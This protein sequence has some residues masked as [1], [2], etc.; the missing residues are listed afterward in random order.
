MWVY[1]A[2]SAGGFYVFLCGSLY[3]L[4]P[5][6]ASLFLGCV[7]LQPACLPRRFRVVLSPP[8]VGACQPA[9]L[10]LVTAAQM[11]HDA[12][13]SAHAAGAHEAA[14]LSAGEDEGGTQG[15]RRSPNRIRWTRFLSARA[16]A[17]NG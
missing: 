2:V 5:M 12:S 8:L 9:C 14:L 4:E 1:V 15:V 6:P 16:R 17:G 7:F 13:A 10:L 11:P 3:P